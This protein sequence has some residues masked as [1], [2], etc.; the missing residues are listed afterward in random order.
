MLVYS[1][2]LLVNTEINFY[3]ITNNMYLMLHAIES[4]HL[5][6]VLVCFCYAT[7]ILN[8]VLL[9][10][11]N[12]LTQSLYQCF[13]VVGQLTFNFQLLHGSLGQ[14]I[15]FILRFFQSLVQKC[16]AIIGHR[17]YWCVCV[18]ELG[19]VY[20]CVCVCM[21]EFNTCTSV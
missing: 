17:P 15:S 19:C 12:T 8:N 14:Y 5:L 2:W 10:H 6:I 18:F 4:M 1:A 11:T 3:R 20:V 16:L 13:T 21:C 7:I 9:Q